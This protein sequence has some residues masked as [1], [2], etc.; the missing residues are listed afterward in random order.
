VKSIWV[1]PPLQHAG[2]TLPKWLCRRPQ[3][4]RTSAFLDDAIAACSF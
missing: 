1:T 2:A 4:A 3:Q